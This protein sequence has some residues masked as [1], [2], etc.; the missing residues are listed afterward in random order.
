MPLPVPAAIA[1][2]R[3]RVAALAEERR[4]L[5]SSSTQQRVRFADLG[6]VD[7]RIADVLDG[8]VSR[9]DPCDASPEVPLVLLPV[10]LETKLAP[11]TSTLRVRIT[12]DEVHL[13]ALVR[14]IT[15]AEHASGRAYWTTLWTDAS[16]TTAWG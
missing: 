3:T 14:A 16:S 9:I 12:P 8:V 13:D 15:P 4:R 5:V 2:A 6:R 1:A 7:A 10:R 11:G